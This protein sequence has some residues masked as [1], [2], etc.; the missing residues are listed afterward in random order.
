MIKP[1]TSKCSIF[2]Y[3]FGKEPKG[4]IFAF[5]TC[6]AGVKRSLTTIVTLVFTNSVFTL[7][8]CYKEDSKIGCI[9][10][11]ANGLMHICLQTKILMMSR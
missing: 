7:P 10:S 6:S 9:A 2:Y 5:W 1:I 8:F 4:F 3:I 11:V